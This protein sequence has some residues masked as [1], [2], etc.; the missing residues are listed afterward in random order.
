MRCYKSDRFDVTRPVRNVA[1]EKKEMFLTSSDLGGHSLCQGSV[2]SQLLSEALTHV[3]IDI[4][5]AQQFLKGLMLKTHKT[6]VKAKHFSLASNR[7][8]HDR[9]HDQHD[10]R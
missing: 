3:V 9:T 7:Q 4:V 6:T 5:G 10:Q 8:K 2:L 1:R